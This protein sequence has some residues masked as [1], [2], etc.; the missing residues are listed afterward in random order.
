MLPSRP[1]GSLRLF[2]ASRIAKAK[3]AFPPYSRPARYDK[4]KAFFFFK[5]LS[6]GEG[7]VRLVSRQASANLFFFIYPQ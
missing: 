5:A 3:P 1:A 2:R 4:A 6:S 7:W